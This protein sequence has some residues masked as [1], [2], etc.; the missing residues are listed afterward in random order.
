V[1]ILVTLVNY[2]RLALV[3]L[4]RDPHCTE[5]YP[6]VLTGITDWEATMRGSNV[7]IDNFVVKELV[8]NLME[9]DTA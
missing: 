2:G 3:I 8:W 1:I 5:W 6:T 9:F 7:R 4:R